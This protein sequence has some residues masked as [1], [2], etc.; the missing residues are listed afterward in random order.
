MHGDQS[1]AEQDPPS[2]SQGVRYSGEDTF[3]KDYVRTCPPGSKARDQARLWKEGDGL[4][5]HAPIDLGDSPTAFRRTLVAATGV[6]L[7]STS[8]DLHKLHS[9]FYQDYRAITTLH[10]VFTTAVTDGCADI[11]FPSRYYYDWLPARY[12]F[13]GTPKPTAERKDRIYW[14]GT[15]LPAYDTPSNHQQDFPRRRFIEAASTHPQASRKILIGGADE[16]VSI[17]ESRFM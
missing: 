1:E 11:P 15:A 9:Q 4:K 2:F 12:Q 16:A 8:P 5:V 13:R 6:E 7:C 3:W 14:R 17:Q 10:P